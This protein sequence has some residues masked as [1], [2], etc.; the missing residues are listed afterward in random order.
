MNTITLRRA[1]A[2]GFSLA[3]VKAAAK[4]LVAA[5]RDAASAET[6]WT[7]ATPV[8]A[9]EMVGVLTST[10]FSGGYIYPGFVVSPGHFQAVM[11]SRDHIP[12]DVVG[13]GEWLAA[14]PVGA[15]V[16]QR[17]DNNAGGEVREYVY[18]R[19]SSSWA[20]VALFVTPDA[21]VAAQ[22]WPSR[23]ALLAGVASALGVTASP[24]LEAVL[25]EAI[26]HVY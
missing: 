26:V 7:G 17:D 18:R 12:A 1:A 4:A 16:R 23:A 2:E 14:A 20:L 11:R 25:D 3:A 13:A 24:T 22:A 21:Q 9:T 15:E 6:V 8:T 10:R 5:H 19:L